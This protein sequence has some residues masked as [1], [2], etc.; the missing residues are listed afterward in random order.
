MFQNSQLHYALKTPVRDPEYDVT[1]MFK[2]YADF[3]PIYT[4]FLRHIICQADV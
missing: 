3:I 1:E 2:Q 4:I